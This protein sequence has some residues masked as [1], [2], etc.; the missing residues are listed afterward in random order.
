MKSITLLGDPCPLPDVNSEKRRKLSEKKKLLIHAPMSDVGGVIYDKDA[1]WINVPGNFTRDETSGMDCSSAHS[2]GHSTNNISTSTVVRGEGERMVIDLQDTA[3]T[4]DDAIARSNVRLL[5]TSSQHL[6]ANDSLDVLDEH[7]DEEVVESS[8]DGVDDS[9]FDRSGEDDSDGFSEWEDQD[10]GRVN[11]ESGRPT[12]RQIQRSTQGLPSSI[13]NQ[14]DDIAFAD[15]DSDLGQDEYDDPSMPGGEGGEGTSEDL[16]HWKAALSSKAQESFR[17]RSKVKH[18]KDW[19]HIIYSS[20]ASQPQHDSHD[21]PDDELFQLKLTDE[22][23]ASDMQE[24][25]TKEIIDDDDLK[26]WQNEDVLERLRVH[27]IT[28]HN[29]EIVGSE[30]EN[31][32]AGDFQDVEGDSENAIP[33]VDQTTS[34][35]ARKEQ[36]KRKFDEQYDDPESTKMDFYDEQKQEMAKQLSLNRAEF[37]DISA[38]SRALVEGFCPG[39]YVRIELT[40]VACELVDN[41]DPTYPII[42]GGLLPAEERFGYVQVRIK[43]HRWYAK[44]LKTNDPLII[45]LGWRRFQSIPIYSLDDHSIRM[46]MLKYTPEHTHCYATF[47]GPLSLPNTGFCAFGSLTSEMAGFRVCATG[48]VLEVDRSVKIVKKLKLTGVPFKI[49]KNTAFVKD[50]FSSALEVAKFEGANIR[51]VSGIRGQ[52]KKALP[53]PDGSF[54]AAFEDKVLSSGQLVAPSSI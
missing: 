39:A 40:N 8:I 49:F 7:T 44:T 41:F 37:A 32:E 34:L 30:N 22:S 33:S 20:Q 42:V 26:E 21:P 31:S 3:A 28:A 13:D 53:K 10:D 54:R 24:D 19:M 15:S 18:R 48:V 38:E 14:D 50:M 52:V 46:R 23:A 47:Y 27:F 16:P 35:A 45:S 51:T 9:E 2:A 25:M 6:T 1:V 12:Q 4:L 43:R 17:I 36:L 5:A 11:V 29:G